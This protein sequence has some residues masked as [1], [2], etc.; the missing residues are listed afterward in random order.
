MNARGALP[1]QRWRVHVLAVKTPFSALLS[2]KD[3]I[4]FTTACTLTQMPHY[5]LHFALTEYLKS[6][7]H[8]MT[9]YFSVFLH[10]LSPKDPYFSHFCSPNAQNHA[11]TQWPHIF[12]VLLSPNSPY[13]ESASL[14]PISFSY[15]SA[16]RL[17]GYSTSRSHSVGLL[18]FRS[19]VKRQR[20]P[21]FTGGGTSE[22]GSVGQGIFF[23]FT[24]SQAL[25][26]NV[27]YVTIFSVVLLLFMLNLIK[28][29]F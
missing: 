24:Y 25:K 23:F 13:F 9:P 7:F 12:Y 4:F 3:P 26:L 11:L 15:W 6:C 19:F 28:F 20:K 8:P 17:L 2:L 10:V 21:L 29:F 22:V 18:Y 27:V 5:V 16:L 1:F 14:T